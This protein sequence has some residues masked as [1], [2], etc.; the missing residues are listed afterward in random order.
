MIAPRVRRAAAAD[1]PAVARFAA[2]LYRLHHRLDP[3][4]FWDLGG[5]APESVAG[6]EGYFGSLLTDPGAV[7]L[8]G[9]HDGRVAGYA[10]AT[11][12]SQD[13][14]NLLER[15]AWLHDVYVEPGA[16]GS[17]LA[18][19]L[20]EAV[21]R[22]AVSAGMPLLA[23]TVAATNARAGAFFARHGA[24]VTMREMVVELP[25]T[26]AWAARHSDEP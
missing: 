9:E 2:E 1:I 10:F 13:Y 18:D 20:F 6:R 16:R 5:D 25:G 14:A 8:V 21:R 7:L 11:F 26:A 12:E 3:A 23:L 24:R 22:E 17:G 15:A 19:A 4:R